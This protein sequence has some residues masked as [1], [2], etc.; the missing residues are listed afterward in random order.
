MAG[1]LPLNS[2]T[3][4]W[5]P[6][7]VLSASI[8]LFLLCANAPAVDE[9]VFSA[10]PVRAPGWSIGRTQ[11]RILLGGDAQPSVVIEVS[12]IRLPGPFKEINRISARCERLTVG[13]SGF[14][15]LGGE[16]RIRTPDGE[17]VFSPA[18][19][20]A[21]YGD[22][23]F[24]FSLTG[25]K[26]GDGVVDVAFEGT[27]ESFSLDAN[28][29]S[30]PLPALTRLFDLKAAGIDLSAQSGVASGKISWR[31]SNAGGKVMVS[32]ELTQL[33]FSNPS[34]LNAGENLAAD[35]KLEAS[36]RDGPW[37]FKSTLS[38]SAGQVYLHPVFV[39]AGEGALEL[40]VNGSV[41]RD[42]ARLLVDDFNFLHQGVVEVEGSA[43]LSLDAPEKRLDRL[44]LQTEQMTL[45]R[46]HA[47][48]IRPWL[49][50]SAF[51][52]LKVSG[53]ASARIVWSREGT[54]EA[55]LVFRQ[56]NL[57][58][59]A[60]RFAVLGLDGE[61][62]WRESGSARQTRVGFKGAQFYRIDV[63]P[64]E[65]AGTF[66]GADFYLGAPLELTILE[67]ALRVD[68]L[69]VSGLGDERLSWSLRGE[70]KPV[71]MM[72]LTRSLDWPPFSGSLSGE[73]P[74]LRYA[75]GEINVDG[76]L[77]VR[78]FDGQIQLEKLKLEQPFGV[79]PRMTADVVVDNLSL[80]ALT[81]TFSFG[82]IEGRLSGRVDDLVLENWRPAAF[83]ARFATPKNDKSRHRIS[84]RAV[85]NLARIGG[86]GQVLSSTLLNFLKSFSYDRLGISCRLR[87]GVCEMG[88][89]EDA[90]RGFYIVKG[91]GFPPRIDVYGF[92]TQVD[93]STLV[94]RLKAITRAKE[95][96]IR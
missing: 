62:H 36:R 82:K 26:L 74:S 58:D 70:L 54:S 90:E 86:A 46:L 11:A 76:K 6:A 83:D 65:L 75:E 27:G 60:G 23:G 13:D 8:L 47:V 94:E 45:A 72:A 69:Q 63:G 92:N 61:A 42:S 73:V 52:K 85:E 33:A 3:S 2:L 12:A 87:N 57:E 50:E 44:V 18:S 14:N 84:Q 55:T 51:S 71:S 78:V 5:S 35:L 93:W 31:Q 10:G 81:S 59:E 16:L 20:E 1:A 4:M 56:T 41:P 7:R 79:V 24:R 15:C 39:D 43:V 29:E 9:I 89:V 21:A 38:L 28:A 68:D 88:G 22:R 32:A 64:A 48:Y 66:L 95:A 96:V 30:L 37:R 19:F 53:D 67:G 34:G 80:G 25:L 77:N 49:L 91:G 17:P 40:S